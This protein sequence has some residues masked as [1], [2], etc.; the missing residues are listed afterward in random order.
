LGRLFE[1]ILDQEDHTNSPKKIK[2]VGRIHH[3]SLTEVG[4]DT[5]ALRR[6]FLEETFDVYYS[7]FSC[8]RLMEEQ[9]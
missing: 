6:E 8:R 4:V 7:L 1:T 5:P 9:V 2:I 3:H